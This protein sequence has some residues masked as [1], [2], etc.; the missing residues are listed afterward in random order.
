MDKMLKDLKETMDNTVLKELDFTEINKSKV[1]KKISNAN[2]AKAKNTRSLY[3]RILSLSFTCIFLIGISYF[4]IHTLNQS[5]DPISSHSD[6]NNVGKNNSIITPPHQDENYEDMKKEDILSKLLNTVDN[7]QTAS[8]AYEMFDRYYDGS[9]SNNNVE[10]KFSL[11]AEIGGY[12]KIFNIPDEFITDDP[13]TTNEIFFNDETIW[14]IDNDRNTYSTSNYEVTPKRETVEPKDVFSI[15]INK[16]YDSEEKFR[17][18]PAIGDVSLFPYEMAAEYLRSSNVWEIERQ[19][20]E[21][22]GHNTIVLHGEIN[23]ANKNIMQPDKKSFRFWVDKDTGILVMYEFYDEE[24]QLI[25]YLHPKELSVNVTIDAKE[26]IP[27]LENYNSMQHY[28]DIQY[29]DPKEKDISIVESADTNVEEVESVLVTLR[30]EVPFLYEFTSS[31]VK[32]FSASLER[33][34]EFNQAYLTYSYKKVGNDLGSGSQVLYVRAY[35]EES[36]VSSLNDFNTEKGNKI[37]SFTLNEIKWEVYEIKDSKEAHFIGVSGDYEYE[38][39]TQDV[40][41]ADAKRLLKT[42]KKSAPNE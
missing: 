12:E 10:Y 34:K 27:K 26:F 38:M 18:I 19:N 8:G 40:S 37:D 4:M 17:E 36:V 9:T 15:P 2:F 6:K 16:L 32:I 35:P 21:L 23:E 25:S 20:E 42:F 1:R 29:E 31:D 5:E 28:S 11:K 3:P 13:I 41:V 22:L 39:I 33:Y 24:G 7:F 30:S 14:N